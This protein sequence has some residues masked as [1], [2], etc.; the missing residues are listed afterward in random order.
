MNGIAP[1]GSLFLPMACNPDW[2][3]LAFALTL[4]LA[5]VSF[6]EQIVVSQQ[7]AGIY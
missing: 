2:T 5:D 6:V 4:P 1:T 3:G 7:V